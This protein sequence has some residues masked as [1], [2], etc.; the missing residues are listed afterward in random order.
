VFD[1]QVRDPAASGIPRK[2]T[3]IKYKMKNTTK[4]STRLAA[5]AGLA[6]T[7]TS[8]NAAIT[9]NST[10]PEA[11]FTVSS[12][13]LLESATIADQSG[14]ETG[15]GSDYNE[16][17]DGAYGSIYVSGTL[18]ID[19]AWDNPAGTATITYDLDLSGAALGYDITSIVSYA[20]WSSASLGQQVITVEYSVVGDA[21]WTSLGTGT[22][23]GAASSSTKVTFGDLTASGVD[24]IRFT[25]GSWT[26]FRE[27]DAIGTATV[28]EP[29]SA[30]LLGLGGLAL[31]FRR[32]K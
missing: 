24:S 1:A 2:T 7:A 8:A 18:D 16:L 11:G 32:R 30:A 6:L 27:F 20:G 21:G 31:I 15:N 13:D 10:N 14:W 25:S 9:Y 12:G 26:V 22:N 29:S 17:T 5:I 28:P 23:A 19:G 3:Q 4:T